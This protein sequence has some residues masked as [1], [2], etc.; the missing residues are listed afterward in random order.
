MEKSRQ[1][2]TIQKGNDVLWWVKCGAR[3]ES[4]SRQYAARFPV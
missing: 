1:T 4:R 3:Q 2:V